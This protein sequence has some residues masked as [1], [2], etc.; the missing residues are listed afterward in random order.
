MILFRT[1]ELLLSQNILFTLGCVFFLFVVFYIRVGLLY[2][3][4]YTVNG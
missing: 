4:L 3:A 1:N 2:A